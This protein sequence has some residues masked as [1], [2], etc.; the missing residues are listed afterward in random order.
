[1]KKRI[2]RPVVMLLII[3]VASFVCMCIQVWDTPNYQGGESYI[4]YSPDGRFRLDHVYPK[5]EVRT[6]R[7]LTSLEDNKIKAIQATSREIFSCSISIK[8]RFICKPD[9][10]YCYERTL[11]TGAY[12]MSLSPSWW[13]QLHAWLTMKH[14]NIEPPQLKVVSISKEYP[15]VTKKANNQNRSQPVATKKGDHVSP[16]FYFLE[17]IHRL[18]VFC[19]NT[20][21]GVTSSFIAYWKKADAETKKN[22]EKQFDEHSLM[23]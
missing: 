22:E 8:P 23:P 18:Y 19:A 7:I 11:Q 2:S 5:T 10:S 4:S 16:F 3:T 13:A 14:Y 6:V 21:C 20:H 1:M 17:C 9:N 15:P 12:R